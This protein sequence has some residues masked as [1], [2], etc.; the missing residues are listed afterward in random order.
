MGSRI[1]CWAL[2]TKNGN[3]VNKSNIE[4]HEPQRNLLFRT[5]R[6]AVA[7]ILGMPNFFATVK[8]VKV[9]VLTKEVE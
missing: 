5:K 3:L 7:H 6:L 2:K 8:P 1:T 4:F 9:A